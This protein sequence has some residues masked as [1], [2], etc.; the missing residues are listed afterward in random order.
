MKLFSIYSNLRDHGR[1]TW[2]SRTD[3]QTDRRTD[4]ILRHKR[5]G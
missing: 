3:G 2:T 5:S 1:P 4:D